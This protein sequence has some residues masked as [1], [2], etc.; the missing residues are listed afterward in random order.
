MSVFF[1]AAHAL[2]INDK[3]KVLV[4]KRAS[5]NDYMPLTWDIPGGTVEIGET[6]E[7]ALIRE[8]KEEAGIDIEPLHPIYA[9]S[10]LSQ[11]PK[12]QTIQLVY[13]CKYRGG[14]IVLNPEE[15]EEYKWLNY[16]EIYK[17]DCIGFLSGL[18]DNY[19]FESN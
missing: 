16:S 9:Y 4:M 3:K 1:V 6:V 10:N 15:H 13:V 7:Q 19:K 11:L 5:C 12:R 17:L 14:D 8:L 2:V 18:I